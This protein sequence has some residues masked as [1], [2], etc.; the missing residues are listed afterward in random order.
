[1][2]KEL[3]K[4]TYL[5]NG[6]SDEELD[7]ALSR[8]SART[9]SYKKGDVLISLGSPIREFGIVLSGGVQISCDDISGNQIIMMSV[10]K[11]DMFAESL[12]VTANRESPIYAVATEASTLLWLKAAPIS[13][14]II[15]SPL[16]TKIITSFINALAAKCLSMNDRV[17]ILSKKSIRDKVITYFSQLAE[18]SKSDEFTIPLSR[19]DMASYLGV[20]RSA[21]SRELSNMQRD[22]IIVY[23]KNHFRIM[24]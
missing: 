22:G 12:A 16:D 19:E 21:L 18:R 23:R 20:E 13:Q 24:H 6:F 10:S 14:G 15:A 4:N 2:D 17:Q 8:L 5:F 9:A 3:L 11:G 1:M 7:E